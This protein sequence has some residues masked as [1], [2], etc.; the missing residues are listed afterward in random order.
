MAIA[1]CL[2]FNT[3]VS[4]KKCLYE[5]RNGVTFICMFPANSKLKFIWS[6]DFHYSVHDS[7]LRSMQTKL[8]TERRQN[9]NRNFYTLIFSR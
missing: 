8:K 6:S 2:K 4:I 5:I 7:T 1:F 3:L 9:C